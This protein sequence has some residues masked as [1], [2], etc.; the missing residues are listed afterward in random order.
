VELLLCIFTVG[1][2]PLTAV[3]N[4][5]TVKLD[6]VVFL[7]R[8]IKPNDKKM[9]D[10]FDQERVMT[11]LKYTGVLETTRLRKEVRVAQI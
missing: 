2:Y 11:Q 8:C 9:A 4:S 10:L 1:L 3:F 6:S 7:S 5:T